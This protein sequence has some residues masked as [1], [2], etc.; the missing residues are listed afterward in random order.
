MMY[1]VNLLSG[2]DTAKDSMTA[3]QS[4]FQK[5]MVNLDMN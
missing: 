2:Q 3:L 4:Q 5:A 1:T